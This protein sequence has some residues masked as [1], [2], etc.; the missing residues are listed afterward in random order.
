MPPIE[1]E[2][3][4]LRAM[5]GKP[6]RPVIAISSSEIAHEAQKLAGKFSISGV[7]PKLS[8][9]LEGDQLVPV[10]RKGQFILKP[11]TQDFAEL[12]QNEYLCMTMGKRFGLRTAPCLLLELADGTPTYL[13]R[14]FDRFK[15]GRRVEKL[16]C[17]DIHQILGGPDK[18]GG[19]HEQIAQAI[20]Q[21]CTFAPLELQRLF[22]VTIFNFTIGNG[23][24]HR[25]NFSLLTSDD[26]T[27]A[28]SPAYDLVSS[29]LAIP[30]E[31]DEMALT[32]NGKR[33]RLRRADF[34]ALAEHLDIASPYAERKI[35]DLLDLQATFT[36]MITSSQLSDAL[37]DG[38][39]QIITDRLDRLR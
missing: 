16:S 20:R 30:A 18:Y 10:A 14:R 12:P 2:D 1:Y 13:V 21:H 25:K 35:G 23:D 15:K 34:R 28:L 8:V 24:A 7:Q 29:R 3:K 26:G 38:L 17:E 37:R 39:A 11:Q 19:S 4:T 5:F 27:I 31:S 6:V 9:R 32:V 22:E 36:E 33:N